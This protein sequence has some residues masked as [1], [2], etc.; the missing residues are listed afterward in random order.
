[1]L[2]VSTASCVLCAMLHAAFHDALDFLAADADVTIAAAAAAGAPS[3]A[4]PHSAAPRS[5][6]KRALPSQLVKQKIHCQSYFPTV[7]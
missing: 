5:L 2:K 6:G 1:M 7:S 3:I 4:T